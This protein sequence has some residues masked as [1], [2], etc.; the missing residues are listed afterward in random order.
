MKSAA[1]VAIYSRSE[2]ARQLGQVC[3]HHRFTLAEI[4]VEFY[5]ID[6]FGQGGSL[7]RNQADVELREKKR[8]L[9]IVLLTQQMN[10]GER[11]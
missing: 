6:A 3:R 8:D 1:S 10:V 5:R 9:T 7:E 2:V 4:L 11:A